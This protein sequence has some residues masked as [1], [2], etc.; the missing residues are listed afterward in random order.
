MSRR[1]GLTDVRPSVTRRRSRLKICST[2]A[3]HCRSR[4][5]DGRESF[6]HYLSF[7]AGHAG[8]MTYF[9]GV[10][11]GVGGTGGRTTSLSAACG[12]RRAPGSKLRSNHV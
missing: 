4:P 6:G 10:A 12:L 8:R 9:M 5:T 1:V 2:C 3:R 7:R 11:S